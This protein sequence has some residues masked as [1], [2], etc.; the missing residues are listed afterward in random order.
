MVTTGLTV[1][2]MKA[3]IG[4]IFWFLLTGVVFAGGE[5]LRAVMGMWGVSTV[6]CDSTVDTKIV[7]SPNDGTGESIS[8]GS[9]SDW[10]AYQFTTFS[11]KVVTGLYAKIMDDGATAT[12]IGEIYTDVSNSPGV[13]VGGGSS[14]TLTDILNT[15]GEQEFI[16]TTPQ[17]LPAGVYW[18]VIKRPA[19]STAVYF[20]TTPTGTGLH[21]FSD[22]EGSS[23]QDMA[24]WPS[25]LTFGV[26][27]CD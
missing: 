23:W 19:G 16:F 5:Q 7:E 10:R 4:I 8:S 3:L 25:Y 17:T 27:G 26:L 12:V 20:Y 2:R 15:P 1:T 24:V 21:K 14:V 22:N 6:T 11:E 13:L 18:V 9:G